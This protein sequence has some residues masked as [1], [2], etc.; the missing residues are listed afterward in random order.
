MILR[1]WCHGLRS[2]IPRGPCPVKQS[3]ASLSNHGSSYC[4][5]QAAPIPSAGGIRWEWVRRS[6]GANPRRPHHVPQPSRELLKVA[7]SKEIRGR[8]MTAGTQKRRSAA[9]TLHLT[10]QNTL[11]PP[12]HISFPC[13]HLL[14][15]CPSLSTAGPQMHNLN[16]EWEGKPKASAFCMT[17]GR[18]G[19]PGPWLSLRHFLLSLSWI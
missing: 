9:F 19:T 16:D 11:N 15:A 6:T 18:L 12:H 1:Q 8:I 14:P 4:C 5:W 2:T 17:R 3:T 7:D 10:K 13:L